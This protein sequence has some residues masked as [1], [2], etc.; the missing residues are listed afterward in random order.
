MK[1][2][3]FFHKI[4]CGFTLVEMAI[5]L[6][7]VA[8]L[9]GGLLPTISAQM[10]QQR[11]SETRKQLDEVQQALTGYSIIN[12]RLPCPAQPNIAS[13]ISGAGVSDCTISTGVLPW[14][15][16]GTSETDAWGRRYSYTASNSFI[17]SNIT[18]AFTGTLSVKS[19][20][21]G[22]NIANSIPAVIVSHGPNGLGAYTTSG[23]QISASSDLD[24][25]DNSNGGTTFV[26][27][28]PSSSFDDLVIWIS[29]NILFNRM[30]SAGILP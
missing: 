11:R 19:A 9:L 26:S 12:R 8:M 21:S 2:Q 28:N 27:H 3:P 4:Q 15:T 14:A 6:A 17:T 22:A 20:A 1:M 18:L 24:E 5:V 7:I 10:E 25:A 29:P 23:V 16:L 13:G 30:V